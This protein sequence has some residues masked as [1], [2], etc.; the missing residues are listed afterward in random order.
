MARFYAGVSLLMARLR[1]GIAAELLSSLA[2][3][4]SLKRAAVVIVGSRIGKLC[5]V[6]MTGDNTLLSCGKGGHATRRDARAH[7]TGGLHKTGPINYV[8]EIMGPS[9]TSNVCLG[10]LHY[11]NQT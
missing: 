7:A 4:G 11:G 8:P 5:G 6:R 1:L 3:L 9:R 10:C 2:M